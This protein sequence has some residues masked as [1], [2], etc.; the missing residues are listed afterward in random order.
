MLIRTSLQAIYNIARNFGVSDANAEIA[1]QVVVESAIVLVPTVISAAL[2]PAITAFSRARRAH[3]AT[4]WGGAVQAL[5]IPEI[6]GWVR[7]RREGEAKAKAED[8][9]AKAKEAEEA[10]WAAHAKWMRDIEESN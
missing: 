3:A 4:C 7:D 6:K 10:R 5:A 9:G 2:P 8:K 1:A